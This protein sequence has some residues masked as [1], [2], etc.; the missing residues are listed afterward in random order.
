MHAIL[1]MGDNS[2]G[3][4]ARRE[5]ARTCS[6]SE[7]PYLPSR[8]GVFAVGKLEAR[9]AAN[10]LMKFPEQD[11]AL[12]NNYL[13]NAMIRAVGVWKRLGGITNAGGEVLVGDRN[14]KAAQFFRVE[15]D[16]TRFA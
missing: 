7:V 14:M 5:T 1:G 9:L 4:K 16:R 13:S 2:E 3:G 8:L 10:I 12:Y 6:D 15:S 11:I